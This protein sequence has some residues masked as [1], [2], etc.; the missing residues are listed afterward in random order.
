M[1]TNFNLIDTLQGT[2]K[3]LGY[4]KPTPIQTRAVPLM[5]QGRSVVGVAQTGTGK[6]LAFVLPILDSLKRLEMDGQSVTKDG[7]PRAVVI[8][9]SRDLGEQVAKVFKTFTH[10]TRL[11]V[12]LATGGASLG[13]ARK[14]TKGPFEVLVATP[15]RLKQLL[16][17]KSVSFSDVRILVFDEVDQM[18]DATF[19]TDAKA[20]VKACPPD[21]Q[22]GLF[23]ATV[24]GKVQEL[25]RELFSEAEVIRIKQKE[26]VVPRLMTKLLNVE[27]GVR[28][29]F[30][31]SE[32]KHPTTG[33]TLIFVN[34]RAQCDQVADQLKADG[35]ECVVYRGEMDK[36]ERRANLI[37]FREGKVNLLISTD[38]AARGLDVDHVSRVINYH[39]PKTKEN[40]IHRV[41]R[42]ARAG[43]KGLVVNLVTKRDNQLIAAVSG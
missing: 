37:A 42:T 24:S 13:T 15:G 29:P 39:L 27:N 28:F 31:K 22:L 40:Y 30:L 9:P 43:R 10:E 8:V 4:S 2:I 35:K 21:P 17:Q 25:M 11:R 1:F 26:L 18:F 34:T 33:G 6:T 3:T 41:G 36:K 20:I 32:L 14:N 7:K 19:L 5:L 12:R 38:L 23:S 16:D